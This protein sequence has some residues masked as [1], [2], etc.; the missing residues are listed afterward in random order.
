MKTITLIAVI[1]MITGCIPKNSNCTVNKGGNS[2]NYFG[3]KLSAQESEN[4]IDSIDYINISAVLGFKETQVE[5]LLNDSS[6]FDE[7]LTTNRSIGYAGGMRLHFDKTKTN[8]LTLKINDSTKC[9]TRLYNQYMKLE[10]NKNVEN[11]LYLNFSN[12][13]QL[14]Q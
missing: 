6:V 5:I 3:E 11:K 12:N 14:T 9:R 13:H 2:I 10:I 1:I 7:R 8:Y 4:I